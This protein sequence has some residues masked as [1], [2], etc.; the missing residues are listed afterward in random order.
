MWSARAD[1]END[2]KIALAIMQCV[3]ELKSTQKTALTR[4]DLTKLLY[5]NNHSFVWT[6]QRLSFDFNGILFELVS[7]D[8]IDLAYDAVKNKEQGRIEELYLACGVSK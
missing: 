7:D 3:A 6:D 4:E 5:K 2:P 8:H 1:Q